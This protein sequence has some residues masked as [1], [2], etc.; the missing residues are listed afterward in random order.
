VIR[1]ATAADLE[2]IRDLLLA[3]G[4]GA[5]V[6]DP[7]RLR[8]IV[9]S[10]TRAVVADEDGEVVGFGR[11]VTDDTSTGYLSMVVVDPRHRRRGMGRALVAAMTGDDPQITWLLRAGREGSDRFWEGLGFRRFATAYE[12]VREQ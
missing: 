12:R 1:P 10:A 9:E 3:E 4:W 8:R 5:R 11:C 7:Q 2:G 6:E